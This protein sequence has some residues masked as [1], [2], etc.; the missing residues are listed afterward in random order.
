MQT[1]L[2]QIQRKLRGHM[3]APELVLWQKI[4]FKQLGVKF[5]RQ[6]AF[7]NRIFDFYAPQLR[8][9]IEVDGATHFFDEE[10]RRQELVWDKM[11][12]SQYKIFVLRVLNSDMMRNLDGVV[13]KIQETIELLANPYLIPPPMAIG[14]GN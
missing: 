7:G 1:H 4:R 14:G 6:Y 2:K 12:W 3:P 11:M 8:L 13:I 5:R 9:A 10:G